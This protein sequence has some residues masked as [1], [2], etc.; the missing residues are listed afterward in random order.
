M[1]FYF[2]IGFQHLLQQITWHS[3]A[4]QGRAGQISTCTSST[5]YAAEGEN[6]DDRTSEGRGEAERVDIPQRNAT[7]ARI[8][9]A[10]SFLLGDGCTRGQDRIAIGYA[11]IYFVW[12]TLMWLHAC[13]IY[14]L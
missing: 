5:P 1:F 10:F 7:H 6:D 4:G 11:S 13:I 8:S 9:V 14:T 2:I 12:R 3:R